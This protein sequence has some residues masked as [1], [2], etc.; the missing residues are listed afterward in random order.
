MKRRAQIKSGIMSENIPHGK[1]DGSELES[2]LVTVDNQKVF[3]SEIV[4]LETKPSSHSNQLM[5]YYLR[6]RNDD[7]ST[8]GP[9]ATLERTTFTG[10]IPPDLLSHVGFQSLPHHLCVAPKNGENNIHFIISIL[11]GTR[12][13]QEFFDTAVNPLAEAL[14]IKNFDVH[15]TTSEHT[16]SELAKTIFLPRAN[17]HIEQ[18]VVLLSGDG[19]LVDIINAILSMGLNSDAV[20]PSVVLLPMGTGNALAHSSGLTQDLTFGLRR[21]V[22]GSPKA[23]P[24][25]RVDFSPGSK[26]VTNEGRTKLPLEIPPY[27]PTHVPAL[28]GAV[29]CSW[30]LHA[31]LVGE[32]DT[33]E[34]R[35]YGVDRF[36]MA[37]KELLSPADGSKSHCYRAKVTMITQDEVGRLIEHQLDRTE[38]MYVLLTLVSDLQRGFTISPNSRPLDGQLRF[39]HFGYMEPTE[40]MRILGLAYQGGKH[41]DDPAV[42]YEA[43]RSVRLNLEEPEERWRRVCVDGKIIGIEEG[44]WFEVHTIDNSCV[45]LVT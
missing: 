21:M 7:E 35:K 16:V 18:T 11:A 33:T 42:S 24:I 27:S 17:Q 20:F 23:L 30:G 19:G 28:A 9:I 10:Q 32:S 44:G 1:V 6:R 25:F 37:A 26:L 14:N 40:A 39:V 29:V 36:P 3:T 38:H 15:V 34:Y 13:A 4:V 45:N 2:S 31:S 41:T 5:G 12:R 43:V 8:G 22:K